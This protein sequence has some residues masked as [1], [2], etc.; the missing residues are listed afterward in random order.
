MN[1][2]VGGADR[3][4]RLVLGLAIVAA[5]VYYKSWWGAIGAV[6]IL[7]AVI[8]WCPAYLPFGINTCSTKHAAKRA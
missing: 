8:G 2:N 5:G 6:P 1:S 3:V 4:V 7:T